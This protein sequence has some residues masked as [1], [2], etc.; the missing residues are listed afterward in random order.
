MRLL[1]YQEYFPFLSGTLQLSICWYFSLFVFLG[2][3]ENT[4][5][6]QLKHTTDKSS[7]SGCKN[8][9]VLIKNLIIFPVICILI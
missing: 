5:K 4:L 8:C 9:Y 3:A 6:M 7:L 1:V 2:W